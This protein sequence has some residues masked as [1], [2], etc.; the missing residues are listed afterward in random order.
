MRIQI[1]NLSFESPAGFKD[2]T[3]YAFKARAGKELCDV[4]GGPLPTGV[5]DLDGLVADR[6]S[7]VADGLRSAASITD[8]G[9]TTL[10]GH[11]ART[12]TIGIHEGGQVQRERWALALDTATTY[13]Q[14][15]YSGRLDDALLAERFQ[16]VVASATA[17]MVAFP[18]PDGYVRRWAGR[19]WVDIPSHLEPPR[20]YQFVSPDETMR[21]GISFLAAASEPTIEREIEQD[22]TLGEEVRARTSAEITTPDLT[23]TLHAYQLT[24]TEDDILID[25]SVRRAHLR[26]QGLPVAHV[27]GRAPSV[28]A[29]A[30]DAAVRALLDSLTEDQRA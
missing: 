1:G 30:L 27:F 25:E 21:L 11:P 16:H 18:T 24:R 26:L 7:D 17:T 28:D 14:V 20:S 12:L 15:A 23:G 29:A 9:A 10:A 6:R 4:G 13:V 8:G 19:L 22:A 2:V 3:G 5:S